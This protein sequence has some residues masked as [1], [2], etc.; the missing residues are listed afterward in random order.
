MSNVNATTNRETMRAKHIVTKSK[1]HN[2]ALIAMLAAVATVLM[3]FEIPLPF[4]APPFYE[5]DFSEVPVLIGTFAMGPVAGI[6][7]ELIKIL[8][9]FIINGTI[10]AGVGEFG[11]FLIGCSLIVPAGIV[12]KQ[13]KTKKHA[14]TGM[15]LGTIF[16][17]IAGCFIN[18][19]LLLPAYSN[20]LGIP[21]EALVGMG[22]AINPAIDDI[23]TFVLFAVG[24][25]NLLK[26]IVVSVLTFI[27]YK[28]V[29]V[30][31]KER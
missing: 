16:M 28:R 20:G 5:L 9:N 22:T 12:Y 4:L 27:L 31:I 6:L 11:N 14:V 3:L 8:L 23:F 10:T 25:F 19:Y 26:G 24:P 7:I 13:K 15:L 17:A 21:M 1:I 18:A 30:L 29:S 2:L